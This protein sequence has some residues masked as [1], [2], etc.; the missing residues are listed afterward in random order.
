[1]QSRRPA[2][3]ASI[4]GGVIGGSGSGAASRPEHASRH[5]RTAARSLPRTASSRLC[6]AARR[7]GQCLAR[8]TGRVSTCLRLTPAAATPAPGPG[9]HTAVQ[10]SATHCCSALPFSRPCEVAELKPLREC[11]NRKQHVHPWALSKC[12]HHQQ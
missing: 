10:A 3:T 1:M 5:A 11:V 4:S 7:V 6:S 8:R 9:P 2:Q 12:L